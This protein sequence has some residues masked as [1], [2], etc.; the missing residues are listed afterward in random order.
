M[1][2]LAASTIGTVEYYL[3][4]QCQHWKIGNEFQSLKKIKSTTIVYYPED[5]DKNTPLECFGVHSND[6]KEPLPKDGAAIE[7]MIQP[8]FPA[9]EVYV[10]ILERDNQS[11]LCEW[12]AKTITFKAFYGFAR[13]FATPEGAVVLMYQ[14]QQLARLDAARKVWIPALKGAKIHK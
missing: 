1:A 5:S 10:K 2:P 12:S 4:E 6:Q 14:T 3:P 8:I 13:L 7:K 11:I 9:G